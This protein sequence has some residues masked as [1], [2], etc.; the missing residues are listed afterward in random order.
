M[1]L[2]QSRKDVKTGCRAVERELFS[3]GNYGALRIRETHTVSERLI[4]LE[5]VVSIYIHHTADGKW[6]GKS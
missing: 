6:T 4:G 3:N 2:Q 5:E 1:Q